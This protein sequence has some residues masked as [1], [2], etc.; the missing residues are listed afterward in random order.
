M[1]V[2]TPSTREL[3]TAG[4][5]RPWLGLFHGGACGHQPQE[6]RRRHGPAGSGSGS[7]SG[8]DSGASTAGQRQRRL[9]APPHAPRAARTACSRLTGSCKNRQGC[10]SPKGGMSAASSKNARGTGRGRFPA[11]VHLEASACSQPPL[12]PSH[13]L[14]PSATGAPPWRRR[15]QG[16]S[17]APLD[18]PALPVQEVGSCSCGR[19]PRRSLLVYLTPP[20]VQT[21][22]V[23]GPLSLS[24]LSRCL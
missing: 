20:I 7:D 6:K 19:P 3:K 11:L 12:A 4:G 13:S 18:R 15:G 23:S 10:T 14:K 17:R 8:S 16:G 22:D 5:V 9:A 1:T 2:S 21:P 24:D